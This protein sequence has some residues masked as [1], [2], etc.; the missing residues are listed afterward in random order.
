MPIVMSKEEW[1]KITKWTDSNREDPDV[2][3]RREYVKNL[4]ES[5]KN[6]TKHWPNSLE[7]VNKRSE[8][9]RRARIEAAEQA[10][11]RFYQQY[12]RKKRQEQRELMYSARETVFK[13]KDAPK[14]LLS[15]VI[16]T[17]I[18]KERQEQIKFNNELKRLE[19]E[20]KKKDDDD[21]I[22]KA[23]E[24]HE[25]NELRKKRRFEVNKQ[26]QKEILD[27]AHEVSERNRIEYESELEMQKVDNIRANEQMDELKKFED[28]FKSAEKGRILSDM[29][30]A[31]QEYE[32]RRK[33][34]E[35]RDK[36][37]DK[38]IQ[39]LQ[40]ATARVAQRRKQTESD[41]KAEKL[42]VL[43]AISKKLES[44]DAAREAL[45]H[46]H[47]Q[48]AIR[49]K[50]A[51]ADA[52]RAADTRKREKFIAERKEVREAFLKKEE[53]RIHEFNTM[54][55]WEIMNR[56]K[57][58]ELYEDF[59]EK[60]KEEK[61][62][63][64]REYREDILKLWR[65]RDEREAK[66]R[67]DTRYFYGE[68]AEKKL[69][70]ADNKLLTLGEKLLDEAREHHRPEYA[71]H[72]AVDRYCK[73]YRL[74]SMPPLPSSMQE[75]YGDYAPRDVSKPDPDY[76]Y[77]AP[78][79]AEADGKRDGLG[80]TQSVAGPSKPEQQQEP[81]AEYKRKGPANGLQTKPDSLPK[82]V[83]CQNEACR[84]DL[85]K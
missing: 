42:R 11:S 83:P 34:A 79:A 82:L 36:C 72:R 9:V 32:H 37:D 35:A 46:E 10:N 2:A 13:N 16:E 84:C 40:K 77:P 58:A 48:K 56:F 68:L 63:K 57:N 29:R 44:G 55:Q 43:E 66:E 75:H 64:I 39:V 74:Y 62:R 21:I 30:R 26:H 51:A 12:L 22:R 80:S 23:K 25:L 33:E 31:R 59:K 38:L 14:L 73:Q 7:N 65:E 60:L 71:L 27:Q 53:Q 61:E 54:R 8:E 52:R 20:Q 24:W 85:K 28:E 76:C 5:S 47:L 41:L 19:E 4:N 1:S 45:E 67:A 49:E 50:E 6:M 18:Q 69:R 70:E 3:R 78:P 81:V 15:A 17:A